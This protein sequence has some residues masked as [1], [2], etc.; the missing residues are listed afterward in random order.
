MK[1]NGVQVLLK[2]LVFF[3]LLVSVTHLYAQSSYLKDL[4]RL[5]ATHTSAWKY[6]IGFE[7]DFDFDSERY[8]EET[9]AGVRF[10]WRQGFAIGNKVNSNEV[11]LR[12][13]EG[14][15]AEFYRKLFRGNYI[16]IQYLPVD[17]QYSNIGHYMGS[18]GRFA[19]QA[20][21]IQVGME[22]GRNGGK[23]FILGFLKFKP[24]EDGYSGSYIFD[25]GYYKEGKRGIGLMYFNHTN[26]V[27]GVSAFITFMRI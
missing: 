12:I 19:Y 10:I 13:R 9:G 26:G 22:H 27:S 20:G 4:S 16:G 14:F 15:G 11:G 18:S 17:V 6:M 3:C 7:N 21:N 5:T 23:N 8:N 1:I 25:A 2:V 24:D